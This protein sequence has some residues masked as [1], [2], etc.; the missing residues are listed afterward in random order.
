MLRTYNHSGRRYYIDWLRVI[1]V[2]TV[3]SV[4][5][6]ILSNNPIFLLVFVLPV[7]VIQVLLKARF[8]E[9]QNWSD[10]LV[11]MVYFILGCLIIKDTRFMEAIVRTRRIALG[12]GLVC[13]ITIM[14]LWM[15]GERVT[16]WELNPVF[17]GG[18]ALYQILRSVN[19]WAWVVFVVGTGAA[20]LNSNHRSLKY[21][22]EAVLPFY[23]L[24]HPV[25][26][27]L[28]FMV[29]YWRISLLVKLPA[30]FASALLVTWGIY[31]LII[32][33]S[34]VMHFLFGMRIGK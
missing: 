26:I 34:N 1:A 22:S 23:I 31:G 10:F 24:H 6:T 16:S 4:H 14:I 21:C 9:H 25:I 5:A 33:R 17:S 11:W 19:S 20:Y 28:V 8:P 13:F 7:A 15:T 32:C 27:V 2:G 12:T 30:F 3:F 18:Y 29:L